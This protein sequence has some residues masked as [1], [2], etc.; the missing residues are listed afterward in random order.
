MRSIIITMHVKTQPRWPIVSSF[1]LYLVY[2]N[3]ASCKLQRKTN[4]IQGRFSEH[5]AITKWEKNSSSEICGLD[6][7]GL[8]LADDGPCFTSLGSELNR[9]QA[10]YKCHVVGGRLAPVNTP[11]DKVRGVRERGTGI[12]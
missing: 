4:T 10:E 6:K 7:L 11:E 5:N 2:P 9:L 3:G 12:V 1:Y 8:R